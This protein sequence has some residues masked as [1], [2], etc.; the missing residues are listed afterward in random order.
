MS[1]ALRMTGA[2]FFSGQ[3]CQGWWDKADKI[4]GQSIYELFSTKEWGGL[5]EGK[6][7]HEATDIVF[8]DQNVSQ[9][10]KEEFRVHGMGYIVLVK[11]E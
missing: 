10:A 7:L 9:K 2:G 3:F 6:N 8:N 5:K 1:W 4:C 11:I